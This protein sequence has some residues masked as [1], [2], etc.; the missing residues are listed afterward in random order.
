MEDPLNINI[1]LEGVESSMPTIPEGDHV[2][3]VAEATIDPN[4][5]K[6]GHNLNIKWVTTET[7]A[8]LDGR[9]IKPNFPVYSVYALQAR[10]DSKDVEA[11]RRNLCD[12]VDA[13]FGTNKSNRP[14][15]SRETINSMIGRS[16]KATCYL[17]E[18]PK[19]SGNFNTK[20]RRVK[21]VS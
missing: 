2:L 16:A 9:E 13:L 1:E 10:E 5:D 4:K 18:Y 21:A 7:L 20:I 8:S 17:D 19:G 6:N 3:Q 11:F 12:L 14:A 15:L